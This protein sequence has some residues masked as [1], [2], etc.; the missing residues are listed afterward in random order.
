VVVEPDIDYY[1]DLVAHGLLEVLPNAL[2]GGKT[3][4]RV[5]YQLRWMA[6]KAEGVP[7]FD[8]PCTIE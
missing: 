8:P 7:A 3:D 2:S 1:K 5:A 6:T 4:P